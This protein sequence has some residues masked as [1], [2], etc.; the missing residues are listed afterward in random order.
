MKRSQRLY[1][2]GALAHILVVG[3]QDGQALDPKA[4]FLR[5]KT[6][7]VGIGYVGV[8]GRGARLDFH[9]MPAVAFRDQDVHHTHQRHAFHLCAQAG[10]I[11]GSVGPLQV[12][13][14]QLEA[15]IE[16]R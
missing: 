7:K 14:G 3:M 4:L 12:G 6:L 2:Q 16:F 11:D 1:I 10:L 5:H 13:I 15:L 8:F 9:Q